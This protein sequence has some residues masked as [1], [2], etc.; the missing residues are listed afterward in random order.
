MEPTVYRSSTRFGGAARVTTAV[1]LAGAV[2]GAVAVAGPLPAVA[3]PAAAQ[4]MATPSDRSPPQLR[5]IRFSRN[6]VKV[7]G[8][9]VVPVTVS[10][11]L[12]DESGVAEIPHAMTVSPQI[13]L[14]PVPGWQALLRP[15]LTRTSGTVRD[16]VWTATV[17]VPS[18]WNGTVRA[19]S[20]G[21]VDR[22]GNVLADELTGAQS[23]ALRVLGTHRPALT[24]HYELLD[25]GGFRIHGRAYY[26]DTG[27]PLRRTPLATA[28]ESGCDLDGGARN[29][30]V[31]DAG[32]RYERRW[33][34]GDT[35]AWACVALIGRTAPRQRPT[36]LAYHVAS[37]PQPAIPD[38]AM[39]QPADLRGA[40][41][42]PFSDDHWSALLPPQ[43]CTGTAYP[44]AALR[45]A[46]RSASAVVGIGERPTVV[47]EHVAVYRSD[48]AHRYLRE[49][50]RGLAA[51]TGPD[52]QGAR[53]TVLATGDNSLFLRR[54]VYLDYADT[55]HDSYFMV[56]RTGRVLIVV[57]GIGWE[58][59]GGNKAL[60]RELGTKALRRSAVLNRGATP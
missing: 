49:L 14:S 55:H 32:G 23:P 4:G 12:T 34:D 22:L 7:R 24:F 38:A 8:L 16:G 36:V 19:T 59:A 54:R 57:A 30:I 29:D 28:Y 42:E 33:A 35:G 10:V 37:A 13:T 50:R 60:T 31:T 44:S 47:L 1:A 39:L 48:G 43:P 58:T 25:A 5:D 11:H 40:T 20:V 9:A 26:T 56:A 18:T 6:S 45:R 51:C 52:Q 2:G 27:R 17:D 53:W 15:V 21:A 3:G 46:S 41:L